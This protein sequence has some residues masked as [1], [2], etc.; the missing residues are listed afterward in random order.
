M[1][2]YV[3][4]HNDPRCRDEMT[5]MLIASCQWHNEMMKLFLTRPFL[6]GHL[7][8]WTCTN[9]AISPVLLFPFFFKEGNHKIADVHQWGSQWVGQSVRAQISEMA[10]WVNINF[11]Y[12]IPC[13][14]RMMHFILDFKNSQRLCELEVLF[15]LTSKR[16]SWSRNPLILLVLTYD[17]SRS[18]VTFKVKLIQIM[19]YFLYY[20]L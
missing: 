19:L 3:Y 2:Y 20:C 16:K 4:M 7:W 5:L 9:P 18:S 12:V 14:V 6:Q 1:I 17:Q 13:Y 8:R 11:K 10:Q 15:V